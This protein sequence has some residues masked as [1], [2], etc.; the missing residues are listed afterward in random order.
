MPYKFGEFVSQYVDPQS[1]KIS[2]LLQNRFM[3]NFKSHD[4]LAL[5]V[6]Q[7]QAALPFENDLAKKKELQAHLDETLSKLTDRGDF[8]NLGFV[9]HK[10]AK[11]FGRKYAPIKQNYDLYQSAMQDLQKR[12]TSK[13]NGINPEQLKY[14]PGWMLGDY[15]GF[16]TDPE[17]G[18][19]K[20]GTMFTPKVVYSDPKI[21]DRIKDRLS[22]LV[23][24]DYKVENVKV[25]QG[26]DGKFKISSGS[27]IIEVKQTDVDKVIQAV[28]EESDVK[29]YVNQLAEMKTY[30][31][32]SSQDPTEALMGQAQS[33]Q[34][35][36]DQANAKLAEGTLSSKDKQQ[37]KD[38]IVGYQSTIEEI[39][40]AAS[41]PNKAT[42]YLQTKIA[43]EIVQPVKDYASLAAYRD[44]TWKKYDVAYDEV[45]RSRLDAEI[46]AG[47]K[48]EGQTITTADKL[49]GATVDEKLATIQS[50]MA[51]ADRLDQEANASGLAQDIVDQKRAQASSLRIDAN[52]MQQFIKQATDMSISVN[53]I[54]KKD[55]TLIGLI[56]EMTPNA[57]SG[58]IAIAMHRIF[59]NPLD[60]DY[61][62]YQNKFDRKYGFGALDA[63]LRRYYGADATNSYGS[64]NEGIISYMPNGAGWDAFKNS[65]DVPGNNMPVAVNRGLG[66]RA[67]NSTFDF[68]KNSDVSAKFVEL[69]TSSVTQYGLLPGLT[70]QESIDATKAAKAYFPGWAIPESISVQG[71]N[72]E[73]I[74]GSALAGYKVGTYGYI[75]DLGKWELQLIPP[76]ATGA[77]S[78]NKLA[79]RT[80]LLDANQINSPELKRYTSSPRMK[81]ANLIKGHDFGVKGQ[82]NNIELLIAG[83]RTKK[84]T[85][86]VISEGNGDP[87]LQALDDNG[88]ITSIDA[89]GKVTTF[90]SD[91]PDFLDL[92]DS[93]IVEIP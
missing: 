88:K 78:N 23:K 67:I 62:D 86:R 35:A 91:S 63:H 26:E 57:T 21:M 52:R 31:V 14:A 70:K 85:I 30:A 51:L 54:E 16:E 73:I 25:G 5:A 36:I 93:G 28:L 58:D 69:K 90:H 56:K 66:L 49:G 42:A 61:Q 71:L 10:E 44:V 46:A 27:Q 75:S 72:G 50:N 60:Q 9:I 8:E 77:A 32:T 48:L 33:Y 74:Q 43:D 40:S 29:A 92:I 65:G 4:Q 82:Q 53:D 24:H 3:E 15:K 20:E 13:E 12:A 89:A 87:L 47:P 2:E 7:M 6:D 79:P 17:T 59:D 83:D 76:A 81:M 34:N 64:N 55:P 19:L 41:D 11:D 1:I 45:W 18:R 22:I 84:I 68:T 37:L 39:K 38:L 80:V